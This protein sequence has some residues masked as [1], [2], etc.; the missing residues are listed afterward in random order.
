MPSLICKC[1][2]AK[3]H[4]EARHC[5]R[6]RDESQKRRAERLAMKRQYRA[7]VRLVAMDCDECARI[8]W[9]QNRQPRYGIEGRSLCWTHAQLAGVSLPESVTKKGC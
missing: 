3:E 9:P 7:L 4:Q 1:G 6:C 8:G 5:D 2:R